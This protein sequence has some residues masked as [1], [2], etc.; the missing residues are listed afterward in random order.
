MNADTSDRLPLIRGPRGALYVVLG[1]FF[2]ALGAIGAMLPVMPTTPF[3]LLAS[4]FFIRSSPRLNDR[5]LRSPF[6]GPFLRDWHEHR[7]VRPHVKVLAIVVM[8]IAVAA[9]IIWG[10]LSWPVL[11]ILLVL[12]AIGLVVVLRLPVI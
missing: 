6:F 3:L 1:C 12:A 2:V 9:S 10:N 5:L 8:L 4:F 7:G 11:V